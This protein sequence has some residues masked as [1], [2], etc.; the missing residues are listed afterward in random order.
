MI[1]ISPKK[2]S[3]LIKT[4]QHRSIFAI[5]T[6]KVKDMQ[7]EYTRMT[8]AECEIINQF[9]NW[10]RK[11]KLSLRAVFD[12][13]R[14]ISKTGMQWRCLKETN[15]PDWQAVYYYFESWTKQGIL[16]KINLALNELARLKEGREAAP[17]LGLADSQSVKLAPMIGEERG[18][19]GN[20]KVNGRKRQILTD[21]GGRIYRVHVHAANRHDSPKGVHLLDQEQQ[22]LE[23]LE[24]ILADN[25]YKGTFAKA[26]EKMGITFEVPQRPEG[27][28]GF[29]VE[30]KRW[31]VERSFAWLNFFRRAVIDFERTTRNAE[32]FVIIA[33][34][35]RVLSKLT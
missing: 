10:Q 8:D 34:I 2:R 20:K 11:R 3:S 33:N 28:R 30:A 1:R 6:K 14:Y 35:S 4:K 16:L 7:V 27:T 31:V 21:V 9:L 25:T 15:F 19:D 18:L 24:K 26:V 5:R 22:G 32:S 29:V 23:K 13:I 12:A 17:S